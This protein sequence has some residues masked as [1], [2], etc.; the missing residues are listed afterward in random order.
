MG[1]GR[2]L[3]VQRSDAGLELDA[4]EAESAGAR[5]PGAGSP[6]AADGRRQHRHHVTREVGR[7]RGR[8]GFEAEAADAHAEEGAE[9]RRALRCDTLAIEQAC[10]H[11]SAVD[12]RHL[13]R[14]LSGAHSE[15]RA[16]RAT[17]RELKEEPWRQTVD[18]AVDG[19]VSFE[20]PLEQHTPLQR[21]GEGR[22]GIGI[23]RPRLAAVLLG[24]MAGVLEQVLLPAD[25]RHRQIAECDVVAHP[26]AEREAVQRRQ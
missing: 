16:G 12:H 2:L 21:L 3:R 23:E 10:M 8:E 14:E 11:G 9:R 24:E 17:A 5:E 15:P 20:S 7:R 18:A 19:V 4:R 25:H 22:E 1:S 6:R 13:D 26:A